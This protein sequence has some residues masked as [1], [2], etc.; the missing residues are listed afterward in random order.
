[1][2]LPAAAALCYGWAA[3]TSL[4]QRSQR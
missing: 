3:S 4:T 2:D 1:V